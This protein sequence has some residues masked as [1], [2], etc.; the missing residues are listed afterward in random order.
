M[1]GQRVGL[2]GAAIAVLAVNGVTAYRLR[3][4]GP[5]GQAVPARPPTGSQGNAQV[6]L[7]P[8][9]GR[10]IRGPRDG[11]MVERRRVADRREQRGGVEPATVV[12][13]A[14]VVGAGGIGI[15]A[16]AESGARVVRGDAAVD[17]DIVTG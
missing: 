13:V 10:R 4:R 17:G 7:Q 6:G 15:V 8:G 11:G 2:E 12:V 3:I 5:Y 1:E 9:P 16:G 14:T